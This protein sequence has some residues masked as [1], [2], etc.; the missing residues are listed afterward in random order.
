MKTP[1]VELRGI[2]KRFGPV[3]ALDGA[4]FELRAGEIHG[5]LGENGAGKTTLMNVLAGL[6]RADAGEVYLDGRPV[7]ILEPRD[8]VRVGVGMVHQHFELVGHFSALENVVLGREG[9]GWLRRHRLRQEVEALMERVGLPVPLD[10]P[11]RELPVGVQQK[12]EILKA[13]YRGARVLVL[14]EPTTLLTPQEV[15]SLFASL[16][17][18]VAA[19]VSVVFI[20]HKLA[21][22]LR[23]CDRITVMRRG[24]RVVT[25]SREEADARQLVE[26]MVG[27]SPPPAAVREPAQ[28]GSPV[29]ELEGV[30]VVDPR[31]V[32]VLEDVTLAVRSGELVGVAG[33]SGNGQQALAGVVAGS[34]R[35]AAGVVRVGGRPVRRGGVADRMREGVL[36]IPEDRLRDGVLPRMSVAENIVLGRHR[37]H[38]PGVRYRPEVVRGLALRAIEQYRIVCPGPDA[39]AGQLSGGNLQKL[40]AARVFEGARERGAR[41]LVAH[42]PTRG[43]DVPST[44]FLHAQLLDFCRH[45][46]GV[47]L[48]SEDL[49]ELMKLSDRITVL[50]RGRVVAEF[51]RVQFDRYAIGRAMAGGAA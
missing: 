32:P 6:Y 10:R 5:L 44:E 51:P 4:D 30:R 7:Q 13:L 12:V 50:Y 16:R 40:I 19:G 45:G 42:N 38:F 34:V 24:R 1:L 11:V 47:L 14:D 36:S 28:P 15:D 43:L 35:P 26:W 33:V 29:L 3:V 41:L 48:I 25:V 9:G 23:T 2:R 20:T 22:V 27:A 39:A 37:L 46:G 49:D 8:A 17:T 31:G 21:E 18:L